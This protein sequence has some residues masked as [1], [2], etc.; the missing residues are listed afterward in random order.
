MPLPFKSDRPIL[1]NNRCSIP[2]RSLNTLNHV[3]RNAQE[4]NKSLKFVSN[5]IK[6]GYMEQV[7]MSDPPP[8]DGKAWWLPVFPV[9]HPKKENIHLVLTTLRSTWEL[10]LIQFY[11]KVQTGITVS[12]ASCQDS[13]KKKWHS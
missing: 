1:P 11:S 7:P 2:K 12:I 6:N 9:H 10:S 4:L 8:E 13:G 5:N 3:R